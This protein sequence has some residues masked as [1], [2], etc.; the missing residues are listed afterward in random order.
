MDVVSDVEAAALE[1]L[2]VELGKAKVEGVLGGT[3]ILE[4]MYCLRSEIFHE[5]SKWET[6]HWSV[7]TVHHNTKN[8]EKRFSAR[9][10]CGW[11]LNGCWW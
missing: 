6:S 8:E 4:R 3:E 10:A 11:W 1:V 9:F 5:G 2:E 7:E